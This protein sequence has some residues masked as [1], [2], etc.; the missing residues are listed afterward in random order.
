MFKENGL[1][2]YLEDNSTL[3]GNELI[4]KIRQVVYNLFMG[5]QWHED[6]F[7]S[8]GRLC[9][10]A[11]WCEG[12]NDEPYPPFV[13]EKPFRGMQCA[14]QVKVMSG[15]SCTYLVFCYIDSLFLC[16]IRS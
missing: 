13:Q 10:F 9:D 14:C 4:L 6:S 12:G 16:H 2:I 11:F 15:C 5:D 8:Q 7:A 1:F 3:E